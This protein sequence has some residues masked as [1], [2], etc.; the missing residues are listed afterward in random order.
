MAQ[1]NHFLDD[2][3]SD[4]TSLIHLLDN[5]DSEKNSE[6]HVIKH[7]PYF[8]EADFSKLLIRK[9][10]LCILSVNIQCINTKFD[11]FQSFI[12]RMNLTNPIS[13][14]CL[15]E[16]WLRD[17][18]NVTMFNLD[19]YELFSQPNQ[20]C[21]HGGLIIYVHKQF[22]CNV[23]TNVKTNS[24]GWEYMCVQLSHNKPRSKK[25]ILCNIYR[26][27]NEIVEDI[28]TFAM[29]LSSF[30]VKVKNLNRPVYVCGDYNIDLLKVKINKHYCRYF[31]E[32]ISNG[33]FP[34][35]TL[36]TRIADHSSTLIDNIFTNN[37]D[38]TGKSGI[39]LNNISDHQIIFTYIEN[40]SYIMEVPKYIEIERNDPRSMQNFV[41]E[42][43]ELN[44]YD[45]LE[46]PLNTNPQEN[47]A[48]FLNMVNIAKNKHLPKKVVRFNKKKH[49]KTKW[50]TNAILKSINTKDT[51]YKT[52]IKTNIE[53][54]VNYVNLKTEFNNYKKIL[55]R[56]INEAKRLYYSRTFELYKN[57][58]KQTW[59]VIKNTLQKNVRC[60]DSTKFVLNNHIITNLDEIANEFNKYF[61]NIGKSLSDQIQSVTTSEDYLLEHNKPDTTFNFV[62]VNE[63]YIDNVINKLKNTSS[64]GY[65]NISNKH[66]KYARN[67]LTKPLTLLINQCL[68]TGIY[69]SQLKLSRVK[70][71]HK[72]GDKTQ[73][74][75][76][77]PISLL[78]SL[79][80]IFERVIFD[81]LLAYFTNNSLLCVNQF[82]FR[83]EHS[84]ELAALKL[85]NSLIA[86]MDSNNVPVNIYIDLSKAFDTLNHSIL[87]SKLEYYGIT[88][89]SYDLLK[90]YL[91][92]RSQYVEFN[93]HISNT[94]PISTGVP[95]GSVLGP[96]LFL[97][98][99]NDLP[100]VS[101]I[102]DM[103]MYADDTTLYCNINQTITAET[104]NRELIKISQWLEANKLSLNV[105][106]TKF[107]V[108]HAS[109]KSVI[110]PELQING[111]NIERVTQ[112]NF[113]GLILESNLSW[114]KHI[115][116][117]SLK[118]SKAI[119]ILY[120]LKSV[121]PLSVLLT[122]YN[123]LVL[124]YFNYGIL[125]WGSII[126]EDHHLHKLQKKAVRIITQSDYIAHT[127]PLCKQNRLIKLPNMFSLAVWKF[128][129]K[130]MNNQLPIYF[131]VMKPVLPQICSRY[132]VRNPV[133]HLPD[134]RHSFAE[135]SIRYC[136]I[137][138]LNAENGSTITTGMVHTSSFPSYKYHIKNEVINNY[139]VFCNID[140]CHV[141]RK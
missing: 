3:L 137:K 125:T 113:L 106:K 70:P 116:H 26:R 119:G 93:G 99:I 37:I 15:Q 98:Y 31:D 1:R 139:S 135:Q 36:P 103:L 51:M 44:I 78:P 29:E 62:S 43:E 131:S 7:S 6:A 10:G 91:S 13:V 77:R 76:Y 129:Y 133:F 96:S 52:L 47:Y 95:Q 74:G 33:F 80:K 101:H 75:N 69:P 8:G 48:T 28:N 57:N 11:E 87:L 128:Y 12:N 46:T 25:Y 32:I 34:K 104:I 105:A 112:F 49:K 121:Y 124:P 88:G 60:P 9:S 20:C 64:Y 58:I 130:L 56:S 23:L 123:S 50:L 90:N 92:N 97:I 122:L 61:V 72:A 67:I 89:R 120:R 17:V 16:C 18:D 118:V 138:Q 81:Q 114:N 71:L 63:V 117:I 45:Q 22:S 115:N 14:I 109:K 55:R 134:I 54:E 41:R 42:L 19:D 4:R 59:S 132:E 94:L 21:A 86:Q 111:N 65:D 38:E 140:K 39:L 85:V 136:L 5:N 84:T 35:I 53:D 82:G 100:L 30:L 40:M 107:M 2:D 127:E 83:P 66:I 102:F 27:P 73:F 24:S 141:C 126:K 110:Y 68:H 79:S 108:F